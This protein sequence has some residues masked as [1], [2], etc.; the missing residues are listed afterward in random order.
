MNYSEVLNISPK[1]RIV[2]YDKN[3]KL[4]DDLNIYQL[5][6][7]DQLKIFGK[8][9]IYDKGNNN[10]EKFSDTELNRGKYV[11]RKLGY[12]GTFEQRLT[13]IFKKILKFN[14]NS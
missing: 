9:M 14:R 11:L 13:G 1:G 6:K 8:I 3:G 5:S 4:R 2:C 7:Q 12:K 10:K